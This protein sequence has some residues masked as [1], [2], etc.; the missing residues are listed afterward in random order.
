V[1]HSDIARAI[2]HETGWNLDGTAED[3]E[4]AG[5]GV[6]PVGRTRD[7][8][9]LDKSNFEVIYSDLS[10]RFPESVSIDR[11]G[12]WGPGWVE[13]ITWDTGNVEVADAV[14]EWRTALGDYPVADEEH[15]SQTEWGDNHPSDSEC[16]SQDGDCGCAAN[17]VH[18]IDRN[19]NSACADFPHVGRHTTD[20][21]EITCDA[22]ADWATPR[23]ATP[24]QLG[25][26][27]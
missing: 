15:Y 9:S 24:G 26:P 16:Y 22:C 3:R 11:F 5:I 1:N 17:Q 23:Y 20:I 2:S 19:E 6:G 8:E 12:H 27:I 4:W 13:E 18:L 14:A 21:D 7:S 10:D 25:L